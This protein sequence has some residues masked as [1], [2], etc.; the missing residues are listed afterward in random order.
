M[1]KKKS[2]S[3]KTS[4]PKNVSPSPV[5]SGPV[6]GEEPTSKHAEIHQLQIIHLSDVHFGSSHK[7]NPD[8]APS[9]GA[10]STSGVKS[11]TDI[12]LEDLRDGDSHCP[13]IIA[14]TGDITTKYEEEGFNKGAQF[15]TSLSTATIC[16]EVRGLNALIAI[17]GNHDIDF[18]KTD[19]N[20]KWYR[21]TKMYN[22][23]FSTSI[24]PDEPLE[25]VNLLD[26][27][28]EG[29]CVLTIN[30]EI[31]VQNNSENQ[32]RGEID[33]EQLKKIEDLL[34]KHKESI[35]KSICIALIHHHPVLIPALVEADRNYD[36]VLRSGHLLNLLN[37]YGFHL[38]L[39]GHKHWP[40]TF[41]V[42]NRN[43]Y[44]Q[45]FVR[46]LLVTAGGSVGSKELPPGLSENCYNRIMVKWNSDTDE[47]RIRVE[48]RGLK[49]TDDSGQPL[50]T[51]ASWEWHPLRVDDRIFYRNERLPAVPYPSPII[52]VEDKTPAHEAHRTGEYA[53]L[54]GNIPVIEVRPSF[55]PFQKYE[56]VFWLAEH[57]SKQFPAERP[58][59]VTWSAGDLFPVLEVDAGDDGRFAG[60]Y[61]YYGPVLVQ[62]TLKFND[63]STEQAYVYARIPSSAEF[64]AV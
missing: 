63:G 28:D 17:P 8:M 1:A 53:R 22:S 6:T 50:P 35:G 9:G 52:S 30:S 24:K 57:P 13:T 62:A 44:D 12:V 60:A 47:T 2:T 19:P 61:S 14:F 58:I 29:Y 32:Y 37:K 38:V 11:F 3:K 43:A 39:H 23:V 31:H 51:R 40:C 18:T 46:P 33:E 7:F 56:A 42:D 20:E 54:R 15:L 48:T 26:R 27:S 4:S 5:I 10:M 25:Y 36:A 49:T 41:T 64:P 45:A 16:G 55:E 34:K 21:W 59:H